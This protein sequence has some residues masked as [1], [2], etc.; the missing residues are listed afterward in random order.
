MQRRFSLP[1][2]RAALISRLRDTRATQ[3]AEFAISLPLL[4]V[5]VVGIF[6]FGAA[7]NL[8]HK[9]GSAAQEGALSAA[10]EV[11]S[12]VEVDRANPSSVRA[13]VDVIFNYLATQ[14]VITNAYVAPC[15]ITGTPSHTTPSLI[16]TYTING[17]PGTLTVVIDRGHVLGTGPPNVIGTEVTVSYTYN[18]QFNSVIG[19][20]VPNTMTLPNPISATADAHNLF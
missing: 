7:Y 20:I 14:K 3:L 18:W 2:R 12:D 4:V 16:W 6:D 9:L 17:C 5:F 15:G 11:T 1:C 13:S 10:G 19:L 8:K